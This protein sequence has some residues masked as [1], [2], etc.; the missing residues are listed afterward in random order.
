MQLW[1]FNI[2]IYIQQECGTK[3]DKA[4]GNITMASCYQKLVLKQRNTKGKY[5]VR[6]S[7]SFC[8]KQ[9]VMIKKSV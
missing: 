9:N 6:I 8:L 2:Y 4:F 1:I 5:A 3:L 7:D